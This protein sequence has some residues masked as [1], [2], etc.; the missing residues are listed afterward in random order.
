MHGISSASQREYL[1][2]R[3]C[4]FVQSIYG[5]HAWG[6]AQNEIKSSLYA[7]PGPWTAAHQGST[8]FDR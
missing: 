5:Y 4:T 3:H 1:L 8:V 6:A 2:L 7:T